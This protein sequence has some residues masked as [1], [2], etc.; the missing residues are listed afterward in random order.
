MN[1]IEKDSYSFIKPKFKTEIKK[2]QNKLR[3]YLSRMLTITIK[4]QAS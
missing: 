2:I 1:E 3:T 4:M